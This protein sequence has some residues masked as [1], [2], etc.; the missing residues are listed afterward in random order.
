MRR[1]LEVSAQAV[2]DEQERLNALNLFPVPDSD[3]GTNLAA[4]LRAGAEAGRLVNTGLL[5]ELF[6]IVARH[7]LD[8]A[9][10]NS[11][12]LLA[13]ML[14]GLAEPLDGATR[15]TAAGLAE[16]LEHARIRVYTALDEPVEGTMLSVVD[17]AARAA[18]AWPDAEDSNRNLAAQTAAVVAAAQ[19]A[20][21]ASTDRLPALAGTGRVDAGALGLL[22]VLDCLAHVVAGVDYPGAAHRPYGRLLD[23]PAEPERRGRV[24]QESTRVGAEGVEVMCSIELDALAAAQLRHRLAQAGD[25][26]I[27]T[28]MTPASERMLWKVHVHVREASEALAILQEAGRPHGITAEPLSGDHA[29]PDEAG[30]EPEA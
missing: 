2:A 4:T 20:V 1:W 16:A 10:G 23:V 6:G 14:A 9:R 7:C 30:E 3:T 21:E 13:V 22:I 28:A 18:A 29:H 26:V 5:G 19:E 17:A 25:S 24:R 15:L 8:E 12:T 27:M 11:G